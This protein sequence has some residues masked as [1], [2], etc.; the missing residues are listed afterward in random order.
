MHDE[1]WTF[2]PDDPTKLGE[3]IAHLADPRSD[4][5]PVQVYPEPETAKGRFG[6]TKEVD[7]GYSIGLVQMGGPTPCVV[8]QLTS[9]DDDIAARLQAGDPPPPPGWSPEPSAPDS[10]LRND[11]EIDAMATAWWIIDAL[12][13][14]G[15][16]LPTGRLRVS[17][18]GVVE[19]FN[20]QS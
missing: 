12:A 15:A 16:P 17:D 19:H 4:G 2:Q 7:T 10:C 20:R 1:L 3:L 13:T 11:G 8:M 9:P 18:P 6:R 5:F 14:L